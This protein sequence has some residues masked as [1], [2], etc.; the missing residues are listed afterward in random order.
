MDRK[1][2][3][4]IGGAVVVA[5]ALFLALRFYGSRSS[6]PPRQSDVPAA[7]GT[8]TV[9]E[10]NTGRKESETVPAEGDPEGTSK[11]TGS[12]VSLRTL[13]TEWLETWGEYWR[14]IHIGGPSPGA[15]RNRYFEILALLAAKT[16]TQQPE[17][18]LSPLGL[19]LLVCQFFGSGE[20]G[21]S[22][23]QRSK[24]F[25]FLDEY[26][27]SWREAVKERLSLRG[28]AQDYAS[29]QQELR[30]RRSI[31]TI[32]SE[33]QNELT[34]SEPLLVPEPS[35]AMTYPVRGSRSD[36]KARVE[37]AVR[38]ESELRMGDLQWARFGFILDSF[39][40]DYATADAETT[41]MRDGDR[42]EVT[43]Q[44]VLGRM[45]ATLRM[46]EAMHEILDLNT[47]QSETLARWNAGFDFVEE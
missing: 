40:T 46:H 25:T 22:D 47:E 26:E 31:S 11:N 35:F 33:R 24:L 38:N 3:L 18:W 14:W 8:R 42:L 44:R 1:V 9:F 27:P 20:A 4:W 28:L 5:I 43:F 29:L 45:K 16:G 30:L 21:L 32:L 17:A 41:G 39:V 36:L 34:W 7:P 2:T 13:R 23:A 10:A 15:I 37:W 12:G 19:P 6:R